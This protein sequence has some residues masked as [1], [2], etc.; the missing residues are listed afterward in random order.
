MKKLILL[1]LMSAFADCSATDAMRRFEKL[2]ANL[3]ER[4]PFQ[5]QSGEAIASAMDILQDSLA[6]QK[7]APILEVAIPQAPDSRQM[8]ACLSKAEEGNLPIH[9]FVTSE[10][11]DLES[12][13]LFN[14]SWCDVLGEDNFQI[15][16][17]RTVSVTIPAD[18]E[19]IPDE[20]FADWKNLTRVAISGS[21]LKTIGVRAF[22]GSGIREIHIPDSVEELCEACFFEC[23]SE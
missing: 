3:H 18:V 17:A 1:G 15:L 13:K 10:F 12:T 5:C 7:S 2:A 20:Y 4:L 21:S 22:A 19:N 11:T 16:K 9:L 6:D 8:F 14:D 23:R